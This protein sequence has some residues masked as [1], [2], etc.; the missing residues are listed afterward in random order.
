MV[1][2][3]AKP[4]P[5]RL[6]AIDQVTVFQA[7]TL[8]KNVPITTPVIAADVNAVGVR[9]LFFVGRGHGCWAATHIHRSGLMIVKSL[10]LLLMETLRVYFGRGHGHSIIPVVLPIG[11][12]VTATQL[13]I[14]VGRLVEV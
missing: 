10:R 11:A 8:L 2:N 3:H 14:V 13:L 9:D 12:R 1:S 6:V 4:V 7:L 5:L